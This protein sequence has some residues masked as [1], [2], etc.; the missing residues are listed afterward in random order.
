MGKLRRVAEVG[1]GTFDQMMNK[2]SSVNKSDLQKAK[3]RK[4][5]FSV[6]ASKNPPKIKEDWNKVGGATRVEQRTFNPQDFSSYDTRNQSIRRYESDQEEFET[7]FDTTIT[8]SYNHLFSDPGSELKEMLRES[9]EQR[10]AAEDN[11]AKRLHEKIMKNSEW[12]R[13]NEM[14]AQAKNR[15]IKSHG[16]INKTAHENVSD[17]RFGHL[18]YD[19]MEGRENQ[20]NQMVENMYQRHKSIKDSRLEVSR[21]QRRSQWEND[22]NIRSQSIQQKA[23][24][25]KLFN[26]LAQLSEN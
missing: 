6:V 22:E 21:E 23:N 24:K 5:N 4:N 2:D 20:Y 16:G 14:W 13:E 1:D 18:D 8:A 15:N 11:N 12:E 9:M 7:P 17:N 25:S 10:I 26:K 3:E 19:A